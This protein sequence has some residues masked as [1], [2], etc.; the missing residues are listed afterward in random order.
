MT[1]DTT[2]TFL[3]LHAAATFNAAEDAKRL[4]ENGAVVNAKENNFGIPPLHAAAMNN[5]AALA[6][7]LI[8]NGAEVNTK[9][10]DGFS[11]LHFAGAE[12]APTVAKLLIDNGA[13]VNAK[14]DKGNYTP[15]YAAAGKNSVRGCESAN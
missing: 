1:N 4:I 10:K 2:T 15:L 3:P 9:A 8:D 6:K 12:N 5:A 7:V 13:D 14:D 11:P